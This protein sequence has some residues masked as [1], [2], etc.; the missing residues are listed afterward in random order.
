MG[1]LRW[2]MP[3]D[4][5]RGGKGEGKKKRKEERANQNAGGI[6]REARAEPGKEKEKT[7]RKK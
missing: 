6:R 4:E 1:T 3:G 5:R 7:Q 2:H